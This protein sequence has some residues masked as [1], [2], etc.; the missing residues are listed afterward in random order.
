MSAEFI[1]FGA[2]P[3]PPLSPFLVELQG[4]HVGNI[5]GY[6]CNVGAK[7]KITEIVVRKMHKINYKFTGLYAGIRFADQINRVGFI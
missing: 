4:G 5:L 3:Y 1:C 7:F 2:G 6:P